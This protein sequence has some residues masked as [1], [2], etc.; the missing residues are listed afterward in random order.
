VRPELYETSATDPATFAL[1]AMVLAGVGLVATLLPARW[2]MA[3][4][5]ART[6]R[7]EWLLHDAAA[8]SIPNVGGAASRTVHAF[9]KSFAGHCS[10]PRG[11][12]SRAV[13]MP[14]SR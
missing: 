2:A 7:S 13:Q 4:D 3:I 8:P 11:P 10:R 1:A 9:P 5:P 6:L 14:T 12:W